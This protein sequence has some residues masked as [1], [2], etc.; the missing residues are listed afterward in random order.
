MTIDLNL[1]EAVATECPQAHAL[2]QGLQS[3]LDH[4]RE[5][6][7]LGKKVR[8]FFM[9]ILSRFGQLELSN[10]KL[11]TLENSTAENI[12]MRSLNIFWMFDARDVSI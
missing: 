8:M 3:D 6:G 12:S 9:Y 4:S 1:L 10:A 11:L 7:N 5:D 2:Q